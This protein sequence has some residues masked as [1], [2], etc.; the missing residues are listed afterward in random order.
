M[1]NASVGNKP[2]NKGTIELMDQ[3]IQ[4][5]Q[6]TSSTSNK[7]Q[8]NVLSPPEEEKWKGK[9]ALKKCPNESNDHQ[10]DNPVEEGK[11]KGKQKSQKHQK[12]QKES[13]D[14]DKDL[15]C[16]QVKLASPVLICF[17]IYTDLF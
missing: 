11:N 15:S 4:K 3:Y 7:H 8:N 5:D 2:K 1:S 16:N 17:T 13:T 12:K 10:Q 9:K 6:G 14:H